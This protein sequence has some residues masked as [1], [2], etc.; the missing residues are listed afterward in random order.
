MA[1]P[2]NSSHREVEPNVTESVLFGRSPA[3]DTVRKQIAAIASA[4]VPVLIE[5][6]S[7]TGKDVLARFIHSRSP[8]SPGNFVKV[9]CA[10]I[11][12]TLLESE[13]F[14]YER[15]AFTGAD[16]SKRGRVELANR[17]TL[18]L[19]EIAELDLSVQAKLLQLLQDGQFCRIGGEHDEQVELRL[20]CATN[21]RL[22]EEI[23]RS[24]FRADLFYR[25]NVINVRMPALRERSCDVPALADHFIGLYNDR[26]NRQAKSLSESL[27]KALQ[28]HSW[29]GNVRELE[30][31]MKRYVILDTEDC[32]LTEL[33]A[34][35]VFVPSLPDALLNGEVSLKKI[36]REAV[37]QI[38]QQVILK[39]LQ[40]NYGNRTRAARALQI[41]YRALLYKLKKVEGSDVIPIGFRSN[42]KPF[43]Q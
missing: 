31:L 10:A 6:E 9:N 5:G 34:G 22:H 18:F 13:L 4:N 21:R 35:N 17:G 1:L 23:D 16:R 37:R 30:N 3:M 36:T 12:A 15:G 20:I 11:P 2:K 24:R 29:P 41:S 27:L 19:D 39:I 28:T 38:E 26:F 40:N 25:I 14:G 42:S 32:I 8:W 43:V 33:S 7:G